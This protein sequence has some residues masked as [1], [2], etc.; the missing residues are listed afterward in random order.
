VEAEGEICPKDELIRSAWP[1]A[2]SDGVT[3]AA[4]REAI[5]R[6]KIELEEKNNIDPFWLST[7][8]GQGYRLQEPEKNITIGRNTTNSVIISGDHNK[9]NLRVGKHAADKEDA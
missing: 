1:G 9:V 5:R 6:L 2:N 7:V 4:V 8:H 3:D